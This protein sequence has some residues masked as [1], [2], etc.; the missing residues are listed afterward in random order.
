[1]RSLNERE[2]DTL[3]ILKQYNNKDPYKR[4]IFNIISLVIWV[5]AMVLC[6]KWFNYKLAFIIFLFMWA[7]NIQKAAVND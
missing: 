6:V 4:I 1:M 3:G 5:V 7:D 2:I